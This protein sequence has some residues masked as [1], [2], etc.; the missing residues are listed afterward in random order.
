VPACTVF[1]RIKSF[2]LLLPRFGG[3]PVGLDMGSLLA[4]G[5]SLTL[6]PCLS[7]G[8][9]GL[10]ALR[11]SRMNLSLTTVL[12]G[13]FLTP[14]AAPFPEVYGGDRQEDDQS[15]CQDDNRDD[16]LIAHRRSLPL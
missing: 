6:S 11:A 15:T 3:V 5:R 13:L 16:D 4:G 2:G 12:T 8:Y 10:A 1:V 9:L 7:F 14:D